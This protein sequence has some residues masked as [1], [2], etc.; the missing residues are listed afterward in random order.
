MSS[1][2]ALARL[3]RAG[4]S[5]MILSAISWALLLLPPTNAGC[6]KIK[7]HRALKGIHISGIDRDRLFC[8]TLDD[9]ADA[10]LLK[11]ADGVGLVAVRF[12]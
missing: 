4:S 1:D 10:H 12:G 7:L 8:L 3:P 2:S 9:F 5:A 11:H 6:L